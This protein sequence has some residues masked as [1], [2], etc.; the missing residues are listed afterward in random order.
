MWS[1]FPEINGFRIIKI[2]CRGHGLSDK[3]DNPADY[4]LELVEDIFVYLIT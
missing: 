4:G 3:S 1:A 2:D